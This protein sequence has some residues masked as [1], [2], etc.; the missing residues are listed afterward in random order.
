MAHRAA[1]VDQLFQRQTL[2]QFTSKQSV[3][4]VLFVG[5]PESKM[6]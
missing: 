6:Q 1:L 2:Y 4:F 5:Q 3:H